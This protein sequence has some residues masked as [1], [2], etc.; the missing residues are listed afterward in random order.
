MEKSKHS[1]GSAPKHNMSLEAGLINPSGPVPGEVQT[2]SPSQLQGE[3]ISKENSFL[4]AQ[5]ER[6]SISPPLLSL[7]GPRGSL[8]H[9]LLFFLKKRL[10][11]QPETN[12][13]TQSFWKW[14]EK[15][16]CW[17]KCKLL[18]ATKHGSSWRK[19][20]NSSKS[21]R[22]FRVWKQQ[23]ITSL[24]NS[25]SLKPLKTNACTYAHQLPLPQFP[26]IYLFSLYIMYT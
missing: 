13:E 1:S 3:E 18:W 16:K 17:K 7:P 25:F 20:Y 9:W 14:K 21:W 19:H 6:F 5:R 15:K 26:S 2:M 23:Q 4:L 8:K 12:K 10:C 22:D 24:F 11:S